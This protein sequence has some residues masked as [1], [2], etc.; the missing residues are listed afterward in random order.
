MKRFDIK[1]HLEAF[2]VN[3]RINH[4]ILKIFS[5]K[6][7]LIKILDDLNKI[8]SS[9]INWD[10]VN[11]IHEQLKEKSYNL[12]NSNLIPQCAKNL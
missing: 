7:R 3:C 11:S 5:L 1:V 4:S 9:P 6:N 2:Y 8:S 10:V 12:L